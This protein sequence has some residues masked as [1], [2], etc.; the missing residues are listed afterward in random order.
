MPPPLISI[1]VPAFNRPAFLE[2]AVTSLLRQTHAS[3][4][5]IVQDGGSD[6]ATAEMLRRLSAKDPRLSHYREPDTGQ[7]DALQKGL[8]KSKGELWS[9]L[10]SDDLLASPDALEVLARAWRAHADGSSAG[11]FGRAAFISEDGRPLRDYPQKL[12]C[13]TREDLQCWWPLAQPASLYRR[14]WIVE[15]GGI[16]PHMHLGMDLDLLLRLLSDGRH[17]LF[18]DHPV[19]AVRLHEGAKSVAARADTAR[20]ALDLVARHMGSPGSFERSVYWGELVDAAGIQEAV[21]FA[22]S[23]GW[24]AQARSYLM[25]QFTARSAQNLALQRKCA[26]L[27]EKL[28][29]ALAKQGSPSVEPRRR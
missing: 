26:K 4:E 16:V 10:C 11:V 3:L 8:L 19:A 27:Q 5:V 17:L 9:W 29:K 21:D 23:R 22:S 18:V 2:E 20:Q 24:E 1:V 13:V 15:C 14:D 7:S 25:D 28:D 6:D 12:G